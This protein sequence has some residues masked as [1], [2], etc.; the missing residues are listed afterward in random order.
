MSSSDLEQK[1][2]E[3]ISNQNIEELSTCIQQDNSLIGKILNFNGLKSTALHQITKA[4]WSEGLI[5]CL[6]SINY[7]IDAIDENGDTA[8]HSATRNGFLVIVQ[9]LVEHNADLTKEDNIAGRNALHLSCRHGYVELVEYLINFAKTN[10]LGDKF[11]NFINSKTFVGVTP[12]H[13]ATFNNH[14]DIIRLLL[15]SGTHAEINA[16]S[17]GKFTPLHHSAI[18]CNQFNLTKEI[19]KLGANVNAVS[20]TKGFTPLHEATKKNCTETVKYLAKIAHLDALT[21]DNLTALHISTRLGFDEV[22]KILLQYGANPNLMDNNNIYPIHLASAN[23]FII[24]IRYLLHNEAN[25]EATDL[26]GNTPLIFAAQSGAYDALDFL[27]AKNS[28]ISAVNQYGTGLVHSAAIG[29]NLKILTKIY[30]LNKKLLYLNDNN[31]ASALHYAAAYNQLDS[32]DYLNNLGLGIDLRDKLGFTALHIAVLHNNLDMVKKLI[33]KRANHNLRTFL[34]LNT[35]QLAKQIKAIEIE[36][37][38]ESVKGLVQEESSSWLTDVSLIWSKI[39]HTP[40]CHSLQSENK[41]L[42]ALS[43][44]VMPDLGSAALQ[45]SQTIFEDYCKIYRIKALQSSSSAVI[46]TEPCNEYKLESVMVINS[47]SDKKIFLCERTKTFDIKLSSEMKIA[48]NMGLLYIFQKGLYA[49]YEFAYHSHQ[50]ITGFWEGV[51][52][53]LIPKSLEYKDLFLYSPKIVV[54]MTIAIKSWLYPNNLNAIQLFAKEISNF[55]QENSFYLIQSPA[56]C[57]KEDHA[58][59]NLT[60][61]KS[62]Y[63]I[64]ESNQHY[65]SMVNYIPI[66]QAMLWLPIASTVVLCL[67]TFSQEGVV[68]KSACLGSV[69]VTV[70]TGIINI[71]LSFLQTQEISLS[72]Y[73][74][75]E[76]IEN[77]ISNK[78]LYLVQS[79]G[80]CAE[81]DKLISQPLS[82]VGGDWKICELYE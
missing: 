20:E 52:Y 23:N 12:L 40:I 13:Y 66:S 51:K 26:Y 22:T 24:S 8:L 63:N 19:I 41:F 64:C 10:F 62:I 47:Y 82:W 16:V 37:F 21:V 55:Q 80:D 77:N 6:K 54:D 4:N 56:V 81:G 42:E 67:Q 43:A 39:I 3:A 9:K 17:K 78:K 58:A 59:Y 61:D 25:I 57:K 72:Q 34:G 46:K 69:L 73:Y 75:N 44:E 15:Q 29:G 33:T 38:L 48:I 31:M 79:P 27:I 70:S 49:G 28:N 7:E 2:V 5:T 68:K 36:K 18:H 45:T 35:Y 53:S 50:R 14:H 71:A 65:G 11:E 32:I 74:A 76:Y 60:Y 30:Q 1:L